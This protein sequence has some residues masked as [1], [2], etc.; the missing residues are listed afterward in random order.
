MDKNCEHI[1]G[2]FYDYIH[3]IFLLTLWLFNIAMENGP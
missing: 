2:E 3:G 1:L